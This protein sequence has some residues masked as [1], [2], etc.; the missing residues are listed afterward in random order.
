MIRPCGGGLIAT[1]VKKRLVG[2]T[3]FPYSP[4]YSW[5]GKAGAAIKNIN[6]LSPSR[7]VNGVTICLG[8]LAVKS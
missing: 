3:T 2:M 8:L 1:I 7:I 5:E 4:I 6:R